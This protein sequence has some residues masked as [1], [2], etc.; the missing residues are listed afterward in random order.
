MDEDSLFIPAE[1]PRTPEQQPSRHPPKKR[2]F[3]E[4]DSGE[5]QQEQ[6]QNHEGSGHRTT[7]SQRSDDFSTRKH[8]IPTHTVNNQFRPYFSAQHAAPPKGPKPAMKLSEDQDAQRSGEFMM[9]VMLR[10]K[11]ASQPVGNNSRASKKKSRQLSAGSAPPLQ[12]DTP[13][14]VRDE[15]PR[16]G[17]K[18][19]TKAAERQP[20]YVIH[21]DDVQ[22][23]GGSSSEFKSCPADAPSDNSGKV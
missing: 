6:H 23:D 12:V 22:D 14:K 5:E 15:M 2:L 17:S 7:P 10:R 8:I 3:R 11:G 9:A 20:A 4:I 16:L 13:E 19:L 1:G 18:Y 21:L